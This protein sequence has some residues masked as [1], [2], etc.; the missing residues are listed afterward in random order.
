MQDGHT[1]WASP[2]NFLLLDRDHARNGREKSE[3]KIDFHTILEMQN[4]GGYGPKSFKNQPKRQYH[5]PVTN[6]GMLHLGQPA[7]VHDFWGRV[8]FPASAIRG[9][10]FENRP[11]FLFAGPSPED[12]GDTVSGS[13]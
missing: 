8:C 5:V 10:G 3:R 9:L 11:T 2:E 12:D 7:C 13:Q 1:F 4:G 6:F